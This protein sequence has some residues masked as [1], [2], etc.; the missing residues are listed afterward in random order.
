MPY[1]RKDNTC[2]REL[3]PMISNT[4]HVLLCVVSGVSCLPTS[5]SRLEEIRVPRALSI[6]RHCTQGGTVLVVAQHSDYLSA[7]EKHLLYLSV[8]V[9]I[10]QG[11]HLLQGVARVFMR[12]LPGLQRCHLL[13]CSAT[14]S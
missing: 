4:V 5:R 1:S 11:L 12:A 6:C 8:V 14:R 2:L 9:A 3:I 7:V 13:L 10:K